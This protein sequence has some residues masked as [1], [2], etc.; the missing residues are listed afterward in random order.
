M[1]AYGKEISHETIVSV[2]SYNLY[3]KMPLKIFENN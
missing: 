3:L 2:I 1:R